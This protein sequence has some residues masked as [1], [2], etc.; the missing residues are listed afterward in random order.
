MIVKFTDL[1]DKI[2]KVRSGEIKEGLSLGIPEIDEYFRLKPAD[3]CIWL[4]RANVGK[5]TVVFYLMTLYSLKHD[6]RWLVFSS[7]NE[8]YA[9]VKKIIEFVTGVVIYNISE[10]DLK[11]KLDWVNKHFKFINTENLYSYK[12]L[13]K[14][15]EEIKKAWDYDGMLLDPYNSLIKDK[16]LMRSAGGHEYDYTAA[17]EMRIFCK[18]HRVTLWINAHAATDSLRKTYP[19]DH[20]LAGY[21]LPPTM[22]DIEGGGKWSNRSDSFCIIDRQ[23]SHPTDWMY[24]NIIVSKIKD[25]DTGGRP[26]PMDAPISM[27]S[28]PDNVGFAINGKNIV[29]TLNSTICS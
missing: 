8:A 17:S 21:P 23:T 14:E 5:T 18:K 9:L 3:F 1:K 28:L 19:K 29:Q 11:E 13:I 27:R 7:E 25:T 4:G 26:T 22:A 10:E 15:A 2:D 12:S 20:D 24:T 16:E 6:I